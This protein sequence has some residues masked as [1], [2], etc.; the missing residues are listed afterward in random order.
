MMGNARR[1]WEPVW[2]GRCIAGLWQTVLVPCI[3]LLLYIAHYFGFDQISFPVGRDWSD[4]PMK[5]DVG[6]FHS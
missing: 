4:E 6:F 3:I 5:S 2:S 1:N